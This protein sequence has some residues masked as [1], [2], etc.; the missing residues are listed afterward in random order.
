[1]RLQVSSCVGVSCGSFGKG[2]SS[3]GAPV[4]LH[5]TSA[6]DPSLVSWT[7][8]IA[9][10]LIVLDRGRA[11]FDGTFE[12]LTQSRDPFIAQFVKDAA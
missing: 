2:R 9:D 8:T 10:R 3:R 5:A 1:M 7:R 11:V 12:C 6:G 4:A